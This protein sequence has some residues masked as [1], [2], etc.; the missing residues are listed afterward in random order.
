MAKSFRNVG[1]GPKKKTPWNSYQNQG[2]FGS[3]CGTLLSTSLV[4]PETVMATIDLLNE[5]PLTKE[6]YEV[7]RMK[8]E[9]ENQLLRQSLMASLHEMSLK[10]SS[11]HNIEDIADKIDADLIEPVDVSAGNGKNITYLDDNEVETRLSDEFGIIV[12]GSNVETNNSNI[13]QTEDSVIISDTIDSFVPSIAINDSNY[14][15]ETVSGQKDTN[16]LPSSASQAKSPLKH[17]V[18]GTNLG[19]TTI[20]KDQ[21]K[22]LV[23]E[24]KLKEIQWNGRADCKYQSTEVED[25]ASLRVRQKGVRKVLSI[26]ITKV[27]SG[28]ERT[29][30]PT[31]IYEAGHKR[32]Q[33]FNPVQ[34]EREKERNYKSRNEKV[35]IT[36]EDVIQTPAFSTNYIP[37]DKNSFISSNVIG[38]LNTDRKQLELV[39]YNHGRQLKGFE[40]MINPSNKTS[41]IDNVI[42]PEL[43]PE[44]ILGVPT[45]V[46]A[47]NAS[48]LRIQ[49]LNTVFNSNNGVE[50]SM[51]P[52]HSEMLNDVYINPIILSILVSKSNI[53]ISKIISRKIDPE[54]MIYGRAPDAVDSSIPT[55]EYV[56][57]RILFKVYDPLTSYEASVPIQFRELALYMYSMKDR[58]SLSK[59]DIMDN[60]KFTSL[61]WWTEHAKRIIIVRSKPNGALTLALSKVAMEKVVMA[62]INGKELPSNSYIRASGRAY[63]TPAT[64]T[65]TTAAAAAANDKDVDEVRGRVQAHSSNNNPIKSH[66]ADKRHKKKSRSPVNQKMSTLSISI[67]GA[68]ADD[69]TSSSP[70][71]GTTL[72]TILSPI[73][74]SIS[75]EL[76]LTVTSPAAKRSAYANGKDKP[77]DPFALSPIIPNK[78]SRREKVARYAIAR[79]RDGTSCKSSFRERKLT[80]IEIALFESPFAQTYVKPKIYRNLKEAETMGVMFDR[81]QDN[82]INEFGR[83]LTSAQAHRMRQGLTT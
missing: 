30:S 64:T 27:A 53:K 8:L 4:E 71:L 34:L 24:Q 6:E 70:V 79:A 66:S 28:K 68:E 48:P 55:N 2:T 43:R 1:T 57:E 47:T 50:V 69:T 9:K 72:P 37:S 11:V 15:F 22:E 49:S 32:H 7:E 38:N 20:S 81:A 78:V 59:H 16:K 33:T 5:K 67:A 62:S 35:Q 77:T 74:T 3:L 45:K 58:Q 36:T 42:T 65:T 61:P 10:A 76:A 25:S 23:H 75:N 80:D 12:Q 31:G 82:K 19:D 51:W 13:T 41:V 18:Y 54:Y 46:I 40:G 52:L 83:E 26:G 63:T 29:T 56:P 44:T 14:S 21:L 73:N 39:A 60:F 17:A